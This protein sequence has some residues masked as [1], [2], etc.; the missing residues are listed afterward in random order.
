VPYHFVWSLAD[1]AVATRSKVNAVRVKSPAGFLCS[2]V[3]Q[4]FSVT[5]G[6]S[7]KYFA[8]S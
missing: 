4:A 8:L 3:I 1:P 6:T 7:E 5:K 2:A